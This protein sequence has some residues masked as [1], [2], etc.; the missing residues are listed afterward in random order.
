V[1][2]ALIRKVVGSTFV[3]EV[4]NEKKDVMVMLC[5]PSL[6][7]CKQA[8]EYYLKLATQFKRVKNLV[9]SEMNVAL[10]DPPV[11]T[12]IDTLPTFLFSP[13]GSQEISPVTPQ[14][15]DEADLAFFLKWKQ[16]IKPQGTKVKKRKEE[17]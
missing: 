16:N 17:L 8:S 15:K 3:A 10:N 14:P 6:P 7:D 2:G 13:R 11:G 9:F 12:A 1:K 5:I 4:G